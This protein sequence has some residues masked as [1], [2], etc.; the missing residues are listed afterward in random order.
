MPLSRFFR[1]LGMWSQWRSLSSLVW[2]PCFSLLCHSLEK[3]FLKLVPKSVCHWLSSLWL[4]V[5]MYFTW[6]WSP[7]SPLSACVPHFLLNSNPTGSFVVIDCS[8]KYSKSRTKIRCLATK[9]SWP[10]SKLYILKIRI[11]TLMGD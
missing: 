8:T 7:E 6:S 9:L 1:Y 11:K 3:V 10:S 4:Y 2:D 5:F